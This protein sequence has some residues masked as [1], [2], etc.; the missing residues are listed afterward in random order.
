MLLIIK[1]PRKLQEAFEDSPRHK[2]RTMETISN[3]MHSGLVGGGGGWGWS[4]GHTNLN[5]SVLNVPDGQ[6]ALN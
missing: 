3:A 6:I 2:V 4:K 1:Y 5:I